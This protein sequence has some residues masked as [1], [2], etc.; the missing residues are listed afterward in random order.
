MVGIRASGKAPT[1]KIV[2][3]PAR[4]PSAATDEDSTP[5][6]S[7]PA[8]P[9]APA[10]RVPLEVDAETGTLIA[11]GADSLGMTSD[12]L[13]GEAVRAYLETRRAAGSR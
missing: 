13:V 8:V 1:V 2:A 3:R 9:V 5:L 10:P 6:D 12:G 7:A 4:R 11:S